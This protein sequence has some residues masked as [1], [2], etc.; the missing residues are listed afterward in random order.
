MQSTLTWAFLLG[1]GFFIFQVVQRTTPDRVSAREFFEGQSAQGQAPGLWLLVS[2]AAISWIFAKSIDNA[3]SL[4]NAFGI[5]GGV[6]YAIYYLSFVTAAIAI[7]WIRVKGG[8][9]SLPDFLVHRYGGLCAKLFLLAIGI[10]LLNEVWSNTKVFSLYFGPEGSAGYWLAALVVTAFTVYYSLWGGLRSSLLTDGAQMLLAAFLLIVILVT[11]GPGLAQNVTSV[12][13]VDSDTQLA[14]LTFCGL[15]A[16]QIFSYPFHDPVLTDRGFIT[17]PKVMVKGFI[18]AGVISGGFIFLFSAVG[19]YSRA[20]G[21][22]GS[23]S[24]AVPQLFGLPMLLIFNVIMLTS[25][26]STLDSTFSSVAK[27]AG[28]DWFNYRGQP[29]ESQA[30]WGRWAM[31]A[32]AILG[33]IPLLSIYMGDQVGP[34]VIRATT[35]SGTMVMG[36]APIFLLAF[37]IPGG[38][39]S[40]HLAFWPGFLCGVLRVIEGA[41][42]TAIFPDWMALGGGK[43]ALDLGVNLY[44]LLLCCGGYGLG[45]IVAPYRS[46]PASDP[47]EPREPEDSG[48]SPKSL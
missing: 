46:Q 9:S 31:V 37:W 35:I 36:L 3:A 6:G 41:T 39:L 22:E 13:A 24:L 29:T 30:R 33:N 17:S 42:G 2:S 18:W 21:L 26:G 8:F 32:I 25:A 7:Y 4:G 10:R 11:L 15:A 38:T 47:L 48:N 1:Y 45:S 23:P 44:G 27:W 34:A 19:L 14:G 43:Y 5:L 28:R 20:Y 40:F 12:M 16:V